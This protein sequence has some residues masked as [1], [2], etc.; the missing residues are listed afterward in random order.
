MP[1]PRRVLYTIPNL[2]TAGSGAAVVALAT[3]LP[4]PTLRRPRA[5]TGPTPSPQIAA[6]DVT[7]VVGFLAS[8]A[9]S[10]IL[11]AVIPLDKA[12]AVRRL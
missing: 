4:A 7:A 8:D 5:R 3:A 11:G 1:A 12:M 2:D 9:S 10:Y 6:D